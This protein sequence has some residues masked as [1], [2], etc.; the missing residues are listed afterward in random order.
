MSVSSVLLAPSRSRRSWKALPRSNADSTYC[1]RTLSFIICKSATADSPS[2]RIFDL[3]FSSPSR[4][5][6]SSYF[7]RAARASSLSRALSV[8]SFSCGKVSIIVESFQS[9][10]SSPLS[11]ALAL[12][13]IFLTAAIWRF[14]S[15]S[16]E[17]VS[18]SLSSSKL[19]SIYFPSLPL[20]TV[21]SFLISLRCFCK[22]FLSF[23]T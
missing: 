21:L 19:S 8:E 1:S 5:W 11:T 16:S 10:S 17:L 3:Y 15:S 7:L 4:C 14:S 2:V 18:E 23:S 9:L 22:E 12:W 20:L 6:D 13:I